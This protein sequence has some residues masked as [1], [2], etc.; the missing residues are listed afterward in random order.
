MKCLPNRTVYHLLSCPPPAEPSAIAGP[1]AITVTEPT[2]TVSHCQNQLCHSVPFPKLLLL[3]CHFPDK[4]PYLLTF[5][6]VPTPPCHQATCSPQLPPLLCRLANHLPPVPDCTPCH[7]PLQSCLLLFTVAISISQAIHQTTYCAIT[8]YRYCLCFCFCFCFCFHFCCHFRL[9]FLFPFLL[10]FLSCLL[11]PLSLDPFP[12]VHMIGT[13]WHSHIHC[14]GLHVS[15][16]MIVTARFFS[17]LLLNFFLCMHCF[18]G[19]RGV[20]LV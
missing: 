15:I 14:G 19:W 7:P 5:S 11:L 9:P 3:S 10:L 16:L 6:T 13:V 2:V 17:F 20:I 8:V 4:S 18:R 12:F 1:P